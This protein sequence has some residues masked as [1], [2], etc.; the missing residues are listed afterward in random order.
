MKLNIY[1]LNRMLSN[2]LTIITRKTDNK[3]LFLPYLLLPNPQKVLQ[4]TH[5]VFEKHSVV[6]QK[7]LLMIYSM[8]DE[9]KQY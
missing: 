1:D 7:Y 8:S 4:N 2:Q 6:Q 5:D 3:C 9:R